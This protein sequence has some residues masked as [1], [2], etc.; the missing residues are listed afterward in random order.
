MITDC[1]PAIEII[2]DIGPKYWFWIGCG[3]LDWIADYL[4][5]GLPIYGIGACDGSFPSEFHSACF[6]D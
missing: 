2:S 1:L 4:P 6:I 5:N 3:R